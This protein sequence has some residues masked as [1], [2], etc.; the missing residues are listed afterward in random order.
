MWWFRLQ[1]L[2]SSDTRAF[3]RTMRENRHSGFFVTVTATM[4]TPTM[5]LVY[6]N[7]VVYDLDYL[8]EQTDY[9]WGTSEWFLKVSQLIH[10][11][12][13]LPW[14][15]H[16]LA[17]YVAQLQQALKDDAPI[18]QNVRFYVDGTCLVYDP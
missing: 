12:L 8:L 4:H 5:K 1:A 6:G 13:E 15:Q 2:L 7:G 11:V 10:V 18:G 14:T 9:Q 16:S 3:S 17:L